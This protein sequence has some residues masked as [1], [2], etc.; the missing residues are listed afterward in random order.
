MIC[1]KCQ[2]T[3]ESNLF[4]FD[5]SIEI[6]VCP[7][8]EGMWVDKGKLDDLDDSII[9][10]SEEAEFTISKTQKEN[11]ACPNCSNTLKTNIT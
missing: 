1:P 9:I 7:S 4:G 10:N 6:G 5:D 8:C 2:D 11:M 3:L